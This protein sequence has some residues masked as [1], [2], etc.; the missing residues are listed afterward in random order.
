MV[1]K[2]QRFV[3]VRLEPRTPPVLMPCTVLSES[4]SH[5]S[6]SQ[7]NSLTVSTNDNAN[8]NVTVKGHVVTL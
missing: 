3:F 2:Q 1:G 6:G 5:N 7:V 8:P 4:R